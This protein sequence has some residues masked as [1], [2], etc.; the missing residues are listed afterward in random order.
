MENIIIR[1]IE[2]QDYKALL[3]LRMFRR[4]APVV[5]KYKTLQKYC[6]VAVDVNTQKAA[7]FI[8]GELSKLDS[9]LLWNGEIAKEYQNNGIFTA[10]LNEIE[11]MCKGKAIM[12]FNHTE[13]DE[14][15]RKRGYR[16]GDNMHVHI[17]QEGMNFEKISDLLNE[18]ET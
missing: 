16:L 8:L 5:A 1:K 11:A 13:L 15:Y 3:E 14:F 12:L 17:K 10:L 6:L 9:C 7:G 4:V 2:W 18:I